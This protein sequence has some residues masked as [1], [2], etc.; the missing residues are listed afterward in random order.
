M[1]SA[2]PPANPQPSQPPPAQETEAVWTYRGYKLRPSD[3]TTA[4]VHF[5]R[6]EISRANVWRQ[7]LDATTNWA[8]LVTGAAFTIAFNPTGFHGVIILN[9]LLITL[10]LVI[11]ARRYRYYELWSYRVRLMET[12]FYAAMLV[13]PFH[14]A[15]EWA[16][17]LA[18]N[19]LHPTYPITMWEAFGRRF[20]RNYM[21]IYVFL[22]IAWIAKLALLSPDVHNFWDLVAN[23]AIGAIPGWAVFTAGVLFNGG[24]FVVGLLTATLHQATGEVLP[25]FVTDAKTTTLAASEAAGSPDGLRAWFRQTRRRQ[26]LLAFIITDKAQDVS[27]LVLKEMRRGMTAMSGVGMYTGHAHSVLMCALTI[28]EVNQLKSLVGQA[29]ANA[30][31]IV[32]PAQEVLGRGFIPLKKEKGE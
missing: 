4:M 9:T 14:P 21:W 26:Q 25:R 11:E 24:L 16:E 32:T 27:A 12:D 7:R 20:R 8:V 10:F 22:G 28:T 5:F 23:A 19:L 15:P 1:D 2:E 17:S 31:V 29:D 13:P 6:A 3:F 18:E 30:F